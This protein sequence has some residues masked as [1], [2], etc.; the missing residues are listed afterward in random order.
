MEQAAQDGELCLRTICSAPAGSPPPP[1]PSLM[2]R[3][4]APAPAPARSAFGARAVEAGHVPAQ[5]HKGSD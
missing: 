2:R 3:R 5:L 4:P 1:I